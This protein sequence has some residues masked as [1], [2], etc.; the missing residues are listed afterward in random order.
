MIQSPMKMREFL[1]L[2]WP[3]TGLYG[4]AVPLVVRSKIADKDG[5]FPLVTVYP[6]KAFDTIPEAITHAK[7]IM[8]EK[9]VF[10]CVHSLS[11]RRYPRLR[12][13]DN[14]HAAKCF[15]FDLDCGPG[16]AEKGYLTQRDAA[17]ALSAFVKATGLPAPMAV[18]SGRGIH[19]YWL[20]DASI[21][22]LQWQVY[23]RKLKQLAVH[24]ALRVDPMRTTD[25]SSLLR[26]VGT[27]HRKNVED[28]RRVETRSAGVVTPVA[29]F[30]SKLE[31]L[32]HGLSLPDQSA[33]RL[34][35][36]LNSI[37]SNIG[38]NMERTFDGPP[39]T[40]EA[41][42]SSCAQMAHL[43]FNRGD[44]TEPEW[45]FGMGVL[46]H[47]ENGPELCHTLLDGHPDYDAGATDRKLAQLEAV[48]PTSCAQLATMGNPKLCIGCKWAEQV[49][50]PL[51]AARKSTQRAPLS[52]T[53]AQPAAE[54]PD[55]TGPQ[56]AGTVL[57]FDNPKFP[58]SRTAAGIMMREP[59]TEKKPSDD[60]LLSPYD[61]FPV[62]AVERTHL[63]KASSTWC[64]TVPLKG[65]VLITFASSAINDARELGAVL[66]D[67]GVYI[68]S[69]NIQN[70]RN[71]MV[72]YIRQ[73][74]QRALASQQ[75]DHLGLSEDKTCFIL[76]D[77]VL[78]AD[79]STRPATLSPMAADAKSYVNKKGTMKRQI[80][81]MGF[82][83]F[84]KYYRHQFVL[85]SALGSILLHT[86]DQA[87]V[88]ISCYGETG[89][90]KSTALYTAASL[91]GDPNKYVIN[92]TAGGSTA[93]AR[94]EKIHTLT[95]LFGAIDEVGDFTPLEA[96]GMAMGVS[97]AS[98]RVRLER[99]GTPKKSRGGN[100]SNIIIVSTNTSLHDLLSR[101]NSGG[102]A[103]SM[104]VLE[105]N[106]PKVEGSKSDADD[107]LR[108]VR[109]NYGHI[110]EAFAHYVLKNYAAVK[111]LV[112]MRQRAI[113][114]RQDITPAE[115]FFS[116]AQACAYVAGDI[117]FAQ[118]WFPFDVGAVE[119]F[120]GEVEIP[121]LRATITG[122]YVA[123]DPINVLTNFLEKNHG[124]ILRVTHTSYT[125]ER[126]MPGSELRG[127]LVAHYDVPAKEIWVIK[128]VFR[129][130]CKHYNVNPLQAMRELQTLNIISNDVKRAIGHGTE[131][132][133]ARTMVF[134]VNVGHPLIA[135][136]IDGA[137]TGKADNV[138]SLRPP[139]IPLAPKE[140]SEEDQA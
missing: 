66:T 82:Y 113:D 95:N 97:Q 20:L 75:H 30:V 6:T 2:V 121:M 68:H 100:R 16:K 45:Y 17:R 108:E 138:V 137:A 76:A 58:Y 11:E 106:F 59:A 132:V 131:Y 64:V 110:G 33:A 109:E 91:H 72:A 24:Y 83:N 73:L 99:N 111:Q 51:N 54:D 62:S 114:T 13:Q 85:M 98:G 53:E 123:L 130:Y 42:E 48:G 29:E 22:S 122:Q 133:K 1:E 4:I 61:M 127:E 55:P 86:L 3:D 105:M 65:Q 15:F 50:Y 101:E 18:S 43:I 104:R 93:H 56:L 90:S 136:K 124:K 116:A 27:F 5:T 128:Q 77:K 119:A 96:K 107:Y 9:N 28:I 10:F 74:Q 31:E 103:G 69:N 71:F 63:E 134:I 129:D 36:Q 87:G 46:K 112:I 21:P 115:R 14:A 81:L 89:G 38:S 140:P 39:I 126:N 34:P 41:L 32:V 125:G 37:G 8:D 118:G 7:S 80:E 92:G 44:V 23:A 102:S 120:M 35:T 57:P 47:V 94:N 117:C 49:K 52:P 84:P 25:T 12:A 88:L 135:D 139:T 67:H 26:V 78:L 19:V 40:V 60:V 79:G 70:M